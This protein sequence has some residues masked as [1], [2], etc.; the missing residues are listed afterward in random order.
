MLASP[1]YEIGIIAVITAALSQV[2]YHIVVNHDFVDEA[3][4]EI[5]GMQKELKNHKPGEK[6]Y[7]E[8]LNKQMSLNMK[9]MKQTMKPTMITIIPYMLM[10]AF[11]SRVYT[12]MQILQL[13]FTLPIWNKDWLGWVGTFILFSIVIST[14]LQ[15]VLKRHRKKKREKNA[16]TT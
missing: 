10:F 13:P 3:K 7:N 9:V 11:L 4:E 14:I 2:L 6:E 5:K 12:D 1:I 16:E 8:I 15:Q